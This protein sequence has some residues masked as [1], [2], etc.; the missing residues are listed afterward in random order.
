MALVIL[1]LVPLG[2]HRRLPTSC[3]KQFLHERP[4]AQ[5]GKIALLWEIFAP[6]FENPIVIR[7]VA[8]QANYVNSRLGSEPALTE[9]R[10]SSL[11]ILEFV[12]L[13]DLSIVLV[14]D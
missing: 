9:H 4:P 14:E 2:H 7:N 6:T 10:G 3:A 8:C 12:F 5:N 11:L 1:L 13:N